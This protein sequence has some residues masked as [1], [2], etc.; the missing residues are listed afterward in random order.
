MDRQVRAALQQLSQLRLPATLEHERRVGRLCA[1]LAARLGLPADACH[2]H[3]IAAELHDV[4]K[5]ALP[6]AILDKPG[7]LTAAEF[8]IVQQHALYGYQVLTA[9]NDS[10]LTLAAEMALCHH[11]RW[12]GSGYPHSLRGAAIPFS[13]RL[14]APC[15]AY[16][17][18]REA[19]PYKQP[20]SHEAAMHLILAGDVGRDG[21]G[22][23]M[24]DPAVLAVLTA[25]PNL[26]HDTLDAPD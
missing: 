12:D 26:F 14:A 3:R 11:E 2:A 19:R 6:D 7:A 13:G 17:A 18:L 5:L 25:H 24:F 20:V 8:A 15:D 23:C 1:A 10:M 16:A 4:G 21:I 22:P 9:A